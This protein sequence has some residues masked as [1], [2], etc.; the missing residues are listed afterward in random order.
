MSGYYLHCI[1][2]K[3]S[4]K[5][6]LFDKLEDFIDNLI[7]ELDYIKNI[8]E[9]NLNFSIDMKKFNKKEFYEVDKCKHCN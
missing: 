9:N 8:N 6:K 2:P 7:D 3:Y 4:K 1:N 5:V